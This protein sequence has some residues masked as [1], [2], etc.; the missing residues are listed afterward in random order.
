MLNAVGLQNVGVR[1]FVEEKLPVLRKYDTAVVANVF[2]YTVEDYAEV[3]RVLEGA[4]GLAAYE[5]NISCPNVKKGGMQFGGDPA[6]VSEVVGV[7]RR[8]TEK[9][10]L[11]V[12]LS[13]LVTDIGLI[14]RAAVE[15]GADALTVANTYPA[16]AVD[17]R[18]RKSRLG[19][20]TGGLSGPAIKPITLRLVWETVKAVRA[21]VIGLG[22]IETVEDVLEY[23]TVGATAVQVGTAS[24]SDP[25][26]SERL[27]RGL[28][29]AS[30]RHKVFSISEIRSKFA[31]EIG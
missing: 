24:F 26:A 25:K 4:E 30:L 16:M 15:A 2:G 22:G 19:N 29:E 20:P 17:L 14:A 21:P 8:A 31:A 5:L 28:E 27:A 9:R 13:P 1:V 10:P 12:K 3:I 11:W 6:A 18:T 7:A 23:V